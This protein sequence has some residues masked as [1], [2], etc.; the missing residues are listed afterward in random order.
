[1]SQNISLQEFFENQQK[2]IR[3]GADRSE[4]TFLEAVA[5]EAVGLEAICL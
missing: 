2:A 5:L 4:K 3:F 1:V